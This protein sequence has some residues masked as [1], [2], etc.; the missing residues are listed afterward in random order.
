MS[1]ELTT[2]QFPTPVET[3]VGYTGDSE[4]TPYTTYITYPD[5]TQFSISYKYGKVTNPELNI[6]CNKDAVINFLGHQFL[7]K[8][9]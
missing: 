2:I 7:L 9:K 1:K 4:Q 8:K 3:Y 5:G 6:T